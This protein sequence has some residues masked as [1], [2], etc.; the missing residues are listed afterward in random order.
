MLVS[1]Q[2]QTIFDKINACE[3]M[4]DILEIREDVADYLVVIQTL[5]DTRMIDHE[6]A[7]KCFNDIEDRYSAKVRMFRII[8]LN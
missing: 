7:E 3:N 6:T 8:N 2:P 4:A 5:F 1:N